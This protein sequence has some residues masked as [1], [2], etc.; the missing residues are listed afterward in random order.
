M[1]ADFKAC[2][3]IVLLATGF[4]IMKVKEIPVANMILSM[5]LVMPV[6]AFWTLCFSSRRM[7]N[8][9]AEPAAVP[10][11]GISRPKITSADHPFIA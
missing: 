1:I 6:S 11:K 9:Q 4:T 5:A 3:G 2:G 10:A 8:T 7:K